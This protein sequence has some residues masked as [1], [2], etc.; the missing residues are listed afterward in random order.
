MCCTGKCAAPCEGEG[1]AATPIPVRN[2][3][4]ALETYTEFD[5]E[6]TLCLILSIVWSNCVLIQLVQGW[7]KCDPNYYIT[8]LYRSCDSLYCLNMLKCCN[9][10]IKDSPTRSIDCE[11][12]NIASFDGQGWVEVPEKKFLAGLYRGKDHTLSSL[13]KVS[14]CGWTRGY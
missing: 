14:A 4:H 5:K 9:F 13:D 11:E 12:V 1:D 10:K 2:C 3:Y 8:G 6:V 7:T